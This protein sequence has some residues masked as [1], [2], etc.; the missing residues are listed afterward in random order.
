MRVHA[1]DAHSVLKRAAALPAD[2]VGWSGGG[3]VA[4]TLAI[5]HP[6]ACRSL[7]LVEP[8]VHGPRAATLSAVTMT[9]RARLAQLRG[10]QRAATDLPTGGRSPI[11]GS[12]ATSGMQCPTSGERR[13]SRMPTQSPPSRMRRSACVTHREGTWR[14]WTCR[15]AS[16]SAILPAYFHR[17]ARHL[18]RLIASAAV[19]SV[20]DAAHAVH[21]DAPEQVAA[22]VDYRNRRGKRAPRDALPALLPVVRSGSAPA[23]CSD[24]SDQSNSDS[25]PANG[26]NARLHP[27]EREQRWCI[28][29]A[30]GRARAEHRALSTV[31]GG[32]SMSSHKGR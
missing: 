25:A 17:I 1:A 8:S 6:A 3:L 4:L 29:A 5:G 18:E 28:C 19:H 11:A 20:P 15:S 14:T 2:V 27:C 7:L 10:G 22:L 23:G 24:A 31:T 21:L 32:A 12:V 30:I 26:E 13:C 9:L 16:W